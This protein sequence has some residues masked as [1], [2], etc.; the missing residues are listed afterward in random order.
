[1]GAFPAEAGTFQLTLSVTPLLADTSTPLEA[2]VPYPIRLTVTESNW[3]KFTHFVSSVVSFLDTL[4][5]ILTALGVTV[6]GGVTLL[7]TRLRK[8]R[9]KQPEPPPSSPAPAEPAPAHGPGTSG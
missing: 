8:R 9:R 6:V 4:G 3:Q 2:A 1:V 5:G 7:W